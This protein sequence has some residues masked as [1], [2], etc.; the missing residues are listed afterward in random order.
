MSDH[1][2]FGVHSG[3]AGGDDG[4]EHDVLSVLE[5][6]QTLAGQTSH[7]VVRACLEQARDDILHLTACVNSPQADDGEAAA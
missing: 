4:A 2:P 1:D 6:L 7:P 5:A 3:H